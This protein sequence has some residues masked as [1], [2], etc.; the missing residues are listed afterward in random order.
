[1]AGHKSESRVSKVDSETT[2]DLFLSQATN[3][4]R[5][6]VVH[7]TASWCMPSVVM[8][9]FVDELA[10]IHHDILFLLVVVDEVKEVASKMEIK[11]MPTFVLMKDGVVV[12][13]LI[14][15]NPDEVNKRVGGLIN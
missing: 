10:S 12:D 2:W 9:P 3:Q 13:K 6:V 14:G 8:E 11:A 4:A 15:A 7:F 5:P 1:M